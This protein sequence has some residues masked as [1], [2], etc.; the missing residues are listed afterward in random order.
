MLKFVRGA[1]VASFAGLLLAG[2]PLQAKTLRF[3][4]QGDYKSLDPYTLNETFTL[5][6]HAA[7]YEGLTK[8]DPELKIIPG[9]A[10]RWEVLDDGKRWRFYLRQGV[11]FHN[12]N[13]FNADDVLFSADRV[14]ADGSDLK[15]RIPPEAKFVKVDDYTV[16]VE[17]PAPNPILHYEWDTWYIMDK[18][19]SEANNAGKPTPAAAT[20]P[21]YAAL[22]ANGTGPFVVES[23]QPGVKTVWKPNPAWWDKPQ[24]NLTEAIF[25]PI[26]SDATRVAALLSGEVD[27]IDPVPLQDVDRVNASANASVMQGPELRTIFLG[28]DQYRDELLYSNVKGKNPFKDKRVREAVYKAIDIEVIKDKVMR[29]AATPSALMISPL[30]FDLSEDFKRPAADPEGAKKLLAEAGYGEGFEVGMD[31]PNDRYVNDERICQAVVGMLARVGIKVNLN[32]QPKAKYFAK[33]LA[34][35]GYDTSF[36]LLG[37]TPGSFDSYNVLA[38]M[39]RCRDEKG[40]GGNNNLGN[41]C[42]PKMEELI[43]QVL[44]E[45]DTKKRNELI[46]AAYTLGQEEDWGYVP[47]HQQALAWGVAKNTKVVQRAD[48]QFL[49]YWVT[50]E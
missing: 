40:N 24:H 13:A 9:L 18:E 38:N 41:Y 17:L 20:T 6:M 48:N 34:A 16:D 29:G 25:T 31:C 50:K 39:Y 22:N 27:W 37:W 26:A 45:T 14:R 44:G 43:K 5:G 1:A 30:L 36:Y 4:F 21:S 15:T 46:K 7:A 47:L 12:G 35:G 42:N 28:F 11:K 3:A 32:A 33:V 10:E 49:F 8:R 19:W 23:H 2:A